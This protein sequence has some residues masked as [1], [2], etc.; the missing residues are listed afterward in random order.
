MS[1]MFEYIK[2]RGDIPFTQVPLTPVDSLI[3]S[4]LVYIDFTGLVCGDL[5]HPVPLHVAAD[6]FSALPDTARRIRVKSDPELLKAMA[7]APRFRDVEL[8]F[9]RDIFIPEEETQFAAMAFFPGDG[10]VFLAFRGTGNALVGWKEDFNMSF[11]D[12]VPAQ[13]EAQRY[14]QDFAE[15]C[16]AVMHLGGHS[17]GG[18]LAVFA[19][20]T[21]AGDVQSRIAQVYNND[22]PGF[23][24][25]LMGHPGY[26]AMVPKIRTYIPESSLIGILLEH[27]E[28]YTVIKSSQVSLMQ[29]EAYSWQIQGGDFIPA[30]QISPDIRFLDKTIKN[31]VAGM[32]REERSKLVDALYALLTAGGA[33]DAADLIHPRNVRA[34]FKALNADEQTR[35]TL[36]KELY[37]FLRS[38]G[39]IRAMLSREGDNAQ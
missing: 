13:L 12:R 10:S 24:D 25:Y 36:S 39:D 16:P 17:K 32:T 26:L 22:G 2:W 3:F 21:C 7:E 6:A 5:R 28:P 11:Q 27:E 8:A 34:F 33:E 9:Y 4:T 23:T 20:S 38:A 18:N 1:D 19:A 31:W 14:L 35:K 29:H 15:A 30:Q 37:R